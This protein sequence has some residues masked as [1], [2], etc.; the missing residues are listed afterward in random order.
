MAAERGL[1]SVVTSTCKV[2]GMKALHNNNIGSAMA[3]ALQSG[4][5]KFTTF[6]ADK[7]LSEYANSGTFSSTDLLDNLGAS[8]IVSDRLT[9]LGKYREF[10]RLVHD[11]DFAQAASLLHSLLWSK[12]APKYFWVTLLIDCIPFLT[13]DQVLFSSNQTYE[14][15]ECLQDLSRDSSLPPKQ[16]LMLEEHEM[17][18]R[19]A[20]AKNLGA[21]LTKEGDSNGGGAQQLEVW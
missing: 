7:L 18:L 19:L 15:M 21:A 16:S 6:L 2:M 4:D 8:I 13:A 5:A 14:L 3:W 10:H 9:F 12:L 1:H 20:L 17:R 11:A